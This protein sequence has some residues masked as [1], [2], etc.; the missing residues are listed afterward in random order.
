MAARSGIN[1]R[2]AVCRHP[3]RARVEMARG[4]SKRAVGEKFGVHPDAAWRHWH[5]HV[6]QHVKA[7]LSVQALKPG[8]ELEKLVVDESL[9]LLQHLQ[10]VR[11]TLYAQFDSAA[12]TGNHQACAMLANQLH[13][14]LQLA[15]TSTGELQKHSPTSVMNVL[16]APA[17]LDLRSGLLRALRAFPE[18][19]AAVAAVFRHAEA[20]VIDGRAIAHEV[21]HAAD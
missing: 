8:A 21:E 11:A 2:C 15:A 19:A 4:A 12:E 14:N 10:R 20:P 9:G 7:T 16:L 5:N 13:R 3:D 17:Y 6:P 1:G 18:A